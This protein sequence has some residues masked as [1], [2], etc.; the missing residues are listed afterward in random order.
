MA[1]CLCQRQMLTVMSSWRCSSET[2]TI[3]RDLAASELSDR[4][5]KIV[6]FASADDTLPCLRRLG[7]TPSGV[8][9]GVQMPGTWNG[10]QLVDILGRLWPARCTGDLGGTL[11]QPRLACP[12]GEICPETLAR[13]RSRCPRTEDGGGRALRRR[14]AC[15]E[16]AFFRSRLKLS[17]LRSVS[18][19]DRSRATVRAVILGLGQN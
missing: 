7:D 8:V 11:G 2:S 12:F 10:L 16:P 14:F 1:F 5:F 4:G 18:P 17:T 19:E 3:V 9:T 13:R 6:E 15:P